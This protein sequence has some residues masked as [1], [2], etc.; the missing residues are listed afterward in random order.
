MDHHK[1]PSGTGTVG[2]SPGDVRSRLDSAPARGVGLIAISA[3]S[4][5][6]G[7][8]V[9][10]HAF[11]TMTPVGVVAARQLVATIVLSALARPRFWRYTHRQ[12]GPLVLLAIFFAGMNT[13]LYAAVDR[14]GLGTAVTLEF[15]GPLAVAL[16]ASRKLRDGLCAALALGGVVLLTRPGPSSDLLGISFGLIAAGCWAGYILTNRVVGRRVQGIEGA[17]VATG[18]STCVMVPIAAVIVWHAQPPW[19][20]FAFAMASG[21]L[22]SAVPY[23]LD[24]IVL[25]H[26]SPLVFGLGMSLHPFFAALLGALF[27]AQH[28]PAIAWAGIGLVIAANALTL[29]GLQPARRRRRVARSTATAAA[30]PP[31]TGAIDLQAD[32]AAVK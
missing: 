1:S 24:L 19:E 2:Q 31:D 23:A 3:L 10:S 28:L 32:S 16:A 11:A 30:E 7:A 5:Q 15:L 13:A 14:I 21:L 20:A 8:A 17:A 9:G 22:S 25:R 6:S 29:M 27:L 18:L 12:W 4:T 26:I